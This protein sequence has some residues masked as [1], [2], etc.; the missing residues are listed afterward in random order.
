MNSPPASSWFFSHEPLTNGQRKPSVLGHVAIAGSLVVFG[1]LLYVSAYLSL[2]N[3]AETWHICPTKLVDK[4]EIANLAVNATP[5]KSSATPSKADGASQQAN[6][7]EPDFTELMNQLREMNVILPGQK[8]RLMAQIHQLQ[9]AQFTACEIGV[10]FF[11]NR[12]ATLTV[13]TAA[14][15]LAISSL[16]F[17]SK[18]GWENS[19]RIIM[20]I[21]IT[22]GLI[23]F[24]TWTFG[25]LYGQGANYENQR[26][27]LVLATTVLNNVASAIAN[28][29]ALIVLTSDDGTKSQKQSLKL[30]NSANMTALIQHL[31]KQLEVINAINFTGDATFAQESVNRIN[32]LLKKSEASPQ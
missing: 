27:K 8:A 16:A 19:N 1:A 29:T 24:A 6:S 15:I 11:V 31:D 9:Q 32:L 28:Q 18:E 30:T 7:Q 4:P 17:V 10:F 21:G 5:L 14:A 13:S 2:M 20:N 22:S 23:L 26:T 25:Q 12:N 3:R